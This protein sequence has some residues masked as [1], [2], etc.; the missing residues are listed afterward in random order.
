MI[1]PVTVITGATFAF[2]SL[3]QGIQVGKDL[4]DMGGALSKWAGS[5][6]DL[7]FV[8]RQNQKPPWYKALGSGVEADAM[9]IFAARKKAESMR[10]ELKTF[11]SFTMGPSAWEELLKIEADI[12]IQ[13]REHEHRQEEIKQAIIEWTLGGFLFSLIIGGLFLFVLLV[14]R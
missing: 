5:M 1:D 7:D 14:T 11:I 8:E 3:K 13:K 9:Q 6:A 12:R 4:E 2:N 10:K